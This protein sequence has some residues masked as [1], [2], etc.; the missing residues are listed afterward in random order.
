IASHLAHQREVE[1]EHRSFT[2]A[3]AHSNPATVVLD[4]TLHDPEPQPGSLF[5]FGAHERLENR[6]LHLG[7]N[8]TTGIGYH[9]P[10]PSTH[11]VER[12]DVARP[13]NTFA[14]L[15]HAVASHHDHVREDLAEVIG[16]SN[17]R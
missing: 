9:Q 10:G 3:A 6:F 12:T 17:H 13:K 7:T 16:G 2:Q 11:S 4:D 8:A 5:A 15:R 14:A 1:L